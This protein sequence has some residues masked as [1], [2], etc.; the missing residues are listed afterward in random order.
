MDCS[1][2][3]GQRSDEQRR[4]IVVS[5]QDH[6]EERLKEGRGLDFDG[7]ESIEGTD[8]INRICYCI[9]VVIKGSEKRNE[10][11]CCFGEEC[12]CAPCALG[13]A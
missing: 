10:A 5:R 2:T 9:V 11:S 13:C 3:V 1:K 4:G 7:T 6:A 8:R 12:R